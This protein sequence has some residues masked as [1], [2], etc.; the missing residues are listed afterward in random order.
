MNY[1]VDDIGKVVEAMRGVG[2]TP[3]YMYGN[4]REIAGRLLQKD[5]DK[6]LQYKK[7]PL[8]AL[9]LDIPEEKKD[10]MIHYTLNLAIL[11]MTDKNYTAEERYQQVLKP[12]LYPLY[13]SF[14][15]HLEKS[16]LFMW[17]GELD[18]PEHTK[19]DRLFWGT[20]NQIKGDSESIFADPIDAIEII[21]LKI[22]QR[23]K[24]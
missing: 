2:E 8:I 11:T 1:I 13:K 20:Y 3:Y 4:R 22:N 23:I 17:E 5:K 6:V 10:G 21:D 15:Q 19:I 14:L 18:E 7:Y 24:K 16:G 9:R 12:I